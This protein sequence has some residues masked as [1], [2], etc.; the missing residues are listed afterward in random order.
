MFMKLS[1]DDKLNYE[2]KLSTLN[3]VKIE[4]LE[5]AENFDKKNKRNK[6]ERAL[7]YYLE[8]QGQAY[9]NK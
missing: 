8:R 1:K 9:R 3:T 6:K 7:C 5:A 4:S 2:I